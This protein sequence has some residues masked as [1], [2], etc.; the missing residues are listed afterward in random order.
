[1]FP[2]PLTDSSCISFQRNTMITSFLQLLPSSSSQQS[3]LFSS[4]KT[5]NLITYAKP[6]LPY[7]VTS[8]GSIRTWIHLGPPHMSS[9]FLLSAFA[10]ESLFTW[11]H[12]LSVQLASSDWVKQWFK[13]LTILAQ[14]RIVW[15][16]IPAS[17]LL[18]TLIEAL[19]VLCY[20]LISFSLSPVFSS[21][22]LLVLII[23]QYLVPLTL[24]HRLIENLNCW[25]LGWE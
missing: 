17:G 18:A 24:V 8:T 10:A 13:C 21:F 12:I 23:N 20:G 6:L 5:L 19:L 22:L 4:L 16:A 3:K 25:L 9:L 11:S 7:R 1:M 2:S 15:W 14:L